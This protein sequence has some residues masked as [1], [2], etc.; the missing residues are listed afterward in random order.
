MNEILFMQL[1]Q[2]LEANIWKFYLSQFLY[3]LFFSIPVIVLFWQDNG[4]NYKQIMSLQACFA[5]FVSIFEIPTGYLSDIIGRKKTII[6]SGLFLVMAII[7]YALGY[8][9]Y[10]FLLG[11]FLFAISATLMSGTDSAFI[12]DTLIDLK[13]EHLYKKIWGHC[14][15]FNMLGLAISNI[16]SGFIADIYSLRATFYAS[17]PFFSLLIPLSFLIYEPKR[18]QIIKSKYLVKIIKNL[19]VTLIENIKLKWLIVYSGLIISFLTIGFWLSQSYLKISGVPIIYFG[20]VFAF[21]QIISAISSKYAYSI[22][23]FLGQKISLIIPIL[24]IAIS[25]LLMS[26][27]V[28]IFSFLFCFLHQFAR[29]FYEPVVSDY[30]NKLVRSDI[31]ATVLSIQS[32]VGRVMYAFLLVIF[33]FITD[34]YGVIKALYILGFVTLVLGFFVIIKLRLKNV[35]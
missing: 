21:F 9:F 19:K 5:V 12:Y 10:N 13:K 20:I 31:R 26:K 25:Y 30:I 33:G 11:E 23:K 14:L 34:E 28:F 32:F 17:I 16:F 1:A 2:K 6:L 35:L 4:L 27:F 15:F 8:S 7:A 18:H 29:G 24:L 3:G 22:E